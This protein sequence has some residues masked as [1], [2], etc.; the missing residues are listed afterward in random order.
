[1]IELKNINLDGVGILQQYDKVVEE[2]EEY[3]E[4]L[5]G[6]DKDHIIEEFWD[7][8]KAKLSLMQLMKGITAE[9]VMKQY[10]KHLEKIRF[11]PRQK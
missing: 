10:P 3:F 4:A 1:M 7:T 11:R 9:E 5:E 6:N 8:V 2:D